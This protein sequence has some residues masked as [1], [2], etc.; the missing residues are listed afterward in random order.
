ASAGVSFSTPNGGT[1]TANLDYTTTSGLLTFAP[2]E[3]SKTFTVPIF[4]DLA[5]E[6]NETVLLQLSNPTGPSTL[7]L[8]SATL[9]IVDNDLGPG[10]FSFS[11][12]VYTVAEDG[13]SATISV[14]RK[15][16]SSGVAGVRF[17]TSDGSATAGSD[18]IST[19]GTLTFANGETV[20]TF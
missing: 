2:G 15:N 19:S 11:S 4:N 9:T 10:V 5:V 12:A 17:A 16:G 1:A 13:G 6:G 20:R 18:Y 14:S 3:V 7:G 8:A